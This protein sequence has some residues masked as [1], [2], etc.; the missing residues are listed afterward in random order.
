MDPCFGTLLRRDRDMSTL[1]FSGSLLASQRAFMANS[2]L[3]TDSLMKLSTGLKIN[4]GSD[5]PSGLIASEQLR[6]VLE[7][8][9][10]ESRALER[11]DSVAA[12]A[13]AAMGE[14]SGLL[15]DAQALAV[16]SANT[17]AMSEAEIEA[18][19]MQMN[20]ILQSIDR[21]SAS[22]QFGGQRLLDGSATLWAGEASLDIG[23][24]STAELGAMQIAI[25]EAASATVD[26]GDLAS[27]GLLELASGRPGD[28][29]SVL[30]AAAARVAM[31]RGR[32]GAFQANSI[33]PML[34]SNRSSFVS[35]TSALSTIR[36]TDFAFESAELIRASILSRSSLGVMAA[37]LDARRDRILML[38]G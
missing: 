9:D 30:A 20:S 7:A 35:T 22:A 26:L 12:V 11:A 17:G 24:M 25:D 10:A 29:Q 37:S 13:D 38:L 31:E 23:S 6:S 4:R 32:I 36:D 18:N 27:G 2:L 8:L 28:I 15:N 33:G 19:Q 3:L 16:A 5:D 34:R 14:V 21:I 1:G